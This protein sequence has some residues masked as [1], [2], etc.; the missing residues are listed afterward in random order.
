MV[1][2]KTSE[3]QLRASKKWKENNKEQMNYIRKRSA[4]KGFVKVA[5]PYDL[6]ELEQLIE[7]RKSK[8]VENKNPL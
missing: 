7:D 6:A 1:E 8:L 3:A 2:K 4:A 5:T